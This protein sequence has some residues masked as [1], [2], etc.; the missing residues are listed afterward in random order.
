MFSDKTVALGDI[1]NKF[2]DNLVAEFLMSVAKLES[3]DILVKKLMTIN[4][5][6]GEKC[7]DALRFVCKENPITGKGLCLLVVG[8]E[9]LS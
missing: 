9:D 4:K 6:N 1:P 8:R 2:V 3:P 5:I 7:I